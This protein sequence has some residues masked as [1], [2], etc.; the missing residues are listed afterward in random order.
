MIPAFPDPRISLRGTGNE[1]AGA[2]RSGFRALRS[3]GRGACLDLVQDEEEAMKLHVFGNEYLK[4]DSFAREVAEYV[5]AEIVSCRSPDEL[6]DAEGPVRILDVVK[7][8][9]SVKAQEMLSLH[10]FDLGFFLKLMK[11]MG[12]EKEIKIIGIPQRGNPQSIAKE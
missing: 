10:D 4:E 5:D 11:E 1:Q 7:D 3:H 6:L 12:M 9:E 8:D 2:S